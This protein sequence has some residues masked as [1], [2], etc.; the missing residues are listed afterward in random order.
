MGAS[1][2]L[3]GVEQMTENGHSRNTVVHPDVERW[4]T[5]QRQR[6]RTTE[7]LRTYRSVMAAYVDDPLGASLE[8]A[9]AWWDALDGY[10]VR[11]R[12]RALSC[13]RSFYRWAPRYVT[14]ADLDR[15]LAG[16][17]SDL[18]RAVA[19]GAWAGLR[20]SGAAALDWSDVDTEARRIHVRSG[21]GQKSRS[22]GM[23]PILDALLPETGGNVVTA[24][25]VAYTAGTL[26]RRATQAKP[27]EKI[28][29]SKLDAPRTAP[30]GA[31][32]R[33]A[34][35]GTSYSGSTLDKVAAAAVR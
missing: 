5:Y 10:G 3:D 35:V 26:Q 6:N 28:G 29:A 19:L 12:A 22:V 16:L 21:K 20:V 4:L 30:V 13:V 14:K 9:Q 27:G 24:G 1:P 31:V 23:H 7:T 34:A 11:T 2:A 17:D 15:L 32:R 25:K 8:E 18:R 33:V